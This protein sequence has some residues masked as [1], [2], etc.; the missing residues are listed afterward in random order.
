M[1][2][3]IAPFGTLALAAHTLGQRTEMLLFMPGAGL[4]MAAGVLAGQN[5][6]A[7]QPERA[8]KSGWMAIGIVEGI[9]VVSAVAVLLWAESIVGIFSREP[10]LVEIAS[11]FLRIATA[12][13]LV[14]GVIIVSQMCLSGV[15]DTLPPMIFTL[16]ITWLVQLPLA[17][18]IPRVT[19]LGVYGV[20]WAMVIGIGVGA[21]AFI[22]YF[23]MGR[24]KRKK[25]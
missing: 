20:R 14:L 5:L 19:D 21:V 12:G 25:V 8:E 6:G 23:R 18:L 3:I 17:L 13:Y 1:M 11:T 16:L 22:S 4:G 10:G 9:M 15:G 7:G 24:W 2:W